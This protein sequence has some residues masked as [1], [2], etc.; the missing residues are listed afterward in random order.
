MPDDDTALL[1]C[2]DQWNACLD[3]LVDLTTRHLKHCPQPEMCCP[4]AGVSLKLEE[5]D[6]HGATTL[7]EL[8]VVRLAR[9]GVR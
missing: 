1:A 2:T 4:G 3:E 5:L 6:F 7:I 8:A 9:G